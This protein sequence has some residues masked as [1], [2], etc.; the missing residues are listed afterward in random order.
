[1]KLR[2]SLFTR[3]DF[4]HG[5]LGGWMGALL[6]SLLGPIL[7]FI[8]PP[9]QEPEKVSL[10]LADYE[11]LEP[12]ILKLFAWGVKPGYIRKKPNGVFE[13]II[14]V[15]THLDC[16]VSYLPE[17]KKFYC[18]CHGGWYDQNGLNIGGP[19]PKPLRILRAEVEGQSLVVK[20]EGVA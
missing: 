3:R 12:G 4:L 9:Y 5:L 16:N 1:M 2:Y 11:G 6:A 10:Q 20:R 13:A 14:A 17:Q 19:P 15:C 8:I 7:K 18:A